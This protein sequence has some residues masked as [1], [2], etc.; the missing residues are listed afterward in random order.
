[1][2]GSPEIDVRARLRLG[3]HPAVDVDAL[4]ESID[5]RTQAD[6]D[7]LVAGLLAHFWPGGSADHHRPGAA[8]W[9]RRWGPGASG[10]APLD[11][12]PN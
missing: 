9:V 2:R 11:G 7:R 4:I 5:H 12:C 10:P 6:A 8:E 1:L 3:N